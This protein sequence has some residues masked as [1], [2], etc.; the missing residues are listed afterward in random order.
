MV[1]YSHF[2]QHDIVPIHTLS[3]LIIYISLVDMGITPHTPIQNRT[4]AIN[5]YGFSLY[6]QYSPV[7]QAYLDTWF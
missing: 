5:A 1:A 6:I 2:C 7:K 3:P 4:Y